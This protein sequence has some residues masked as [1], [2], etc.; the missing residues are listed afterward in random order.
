MSY[1]L[2][3]DGV[4]PQKRRLGSKVPLAAA[5]VVD[6]DTASSRNTGPSRSTS[7][8]VRETSH[9]LGVPIVRTKL[10]TGA[11]VAVVDTLYSAGSDIDGRCIWEQGA[12]PVKTFSHSMDTSIYPIASTRDLHQ[13]LLRSVRWVAQFSGVASI[14]DKQ[15]EWE[16]CTT[17]DTSVNDASH[18]E[19]FGQDRR[20]GDGR[21]A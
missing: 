16:Y 18:T 20:T 10:A 1:P 2:G 7:M 11:E 14:L 5:A 12:T 3:V 13:R 8:A 19:A 4:G 17:D 15:P 21:R 6:A 9:A